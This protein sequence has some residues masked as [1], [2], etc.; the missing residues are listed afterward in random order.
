MKNLSIAAKMGLLVAVLLGTTLTLAITGLSQ[1]SGLTRFEAAL[2]A[3]GDQIELASQARREFL[4]AVRAEKN[5]VLVS[6]KAQATDFADAARKHLASAQDLRNRLS[7]SFDSST[8]TAE[9]KHLA[10][11]DRAIEEFERN[12]KESLRLAVIKSNVDGW[13]ILDKDLHQRAHDAEEFVASLSEPGPEGSP[14]TRTSTAS[15]TPAAAAGQVLIGR[16]YDLL[17]HVGLHLNAAD[18]KEMSRMDGELR[19]RVIAVQESLRRLSVQL[20]E[21]ERSRGAAVMAALESLKPQVL[22]VQDLSHMNSDIAARQLTVVNTVELVNRADAALAALLGSLRQQMDNERKTLERAI[23]MGRSVIISTAAIG[24]LIALA[25]AILMIRSITRPVTHGV[26]V[27]EAIAAG[28]LTRRMNLDQRDEIGRLGAASDRMVDSVSQVVTQARALAD[29]LDRSAGELSDVS[30]DMLSQSQ[31]MATQA[32]SVAAATEQMSSNISGMAA[33]AEQMSVNVSSISSASE[34]VSVNVGSISASAAQTSGNVGAVAESIGHIT[35]SL[36]G[37]ATD[38]REGSQMSQ[39]ARDMA[40]SAN[41]AMR[42]LDQSAGEINKVTEVIKTI[43]LQ[44]NLLALNAT[45]EATSAGEAGKGFA[46]V[47]GEVKELASQSA[48]SAEE[49]ARKIE[50]VQAST[51]EA[52]KVID[53][54]AQFINQLSVSAGR[55]SNA[56]ETQTRT[57]NQ[58]STEVASARKG[59]E[60]IARSIAEVAKG[61]TDVSGNT[62]EVSKAAADVSRNAAEAAEAAQSISPNIHGVSEATRLNG[63]SAARVNEAAV[64]LKS[65]SRELLQTVSQF[66]TGA[67]GSASPQRHG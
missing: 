62:A 31:E 41:Q 46:V 15:L 27:F 48:Q 58:I 54:V 20:N 67:N 14:A 30:H 6:D 23:L 37:V 65:I 57:A 56:V 12:Q 9:G 34:E 3:T 11:L 13:M 19:P 8:A 2:S 64:R 49:I 63:A 26:Q 35:A 42:Q 44:T 16:L 24:S 25:L 18:D 61:A 22:H 4:L 47:A 59:V 36:T 40:A 52:V 28:D 60:E 53:G 45:I 55:I 5:A 50:S 32:E 10:D 29:Q 39:Q 7:S 43:A 17:F 21:A 33:A 66:K 38:A 51:R 1:L